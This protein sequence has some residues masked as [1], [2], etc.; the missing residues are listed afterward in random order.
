[1]QFEMSSEKIG[2]NSEVRL[3]SSDTDGEGVDPSQVP[4]KTK[5]TFNHFRSWNFLYTIQ[6]DILGEPG[7]SIDAKKIL[8]SEHLRTR[9]GHNRPPAVVSVTVFCDFT[10]V[11]APPQGT[12]PLISVPIVGFVQSESR[13]VHAMTGWFSDAKW[14]P[15]PGGLADHPDFLRYMSLVENTAGPWFKLSVFGELGLNNAGRRAARENRKVFL[16]PFIHFLARPS[17]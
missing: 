3:Q 12:S 9:L 10:F 11:L 15:V 1:M 13:T 2:I 6:T 7:V 8:L 16:K 14:A 17:D 4:T 5:R